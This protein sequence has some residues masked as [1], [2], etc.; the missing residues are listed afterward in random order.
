M[1]DSCPCHAPILRAAVPARPQDAADR[2]RLGASTFK[3]LNL[4]LAALEYGYSVI[5]SAAILSDQA[6]RVALT[7]TRADRKRCACG[8]HGTAV[9]LACHTV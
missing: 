5:F 4:G 7:G 1:P 6:S 9:C 2:G 8:W 3:N